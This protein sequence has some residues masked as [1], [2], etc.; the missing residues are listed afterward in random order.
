M[1]AIARWPTTP[2]KVGQTAEE[3]DGQWTETI[4]HIVLVS[5]GF[6][7]S[8]NFGGKVEWEEVEDRT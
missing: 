8:V 5:S 6:E 1:F 2:R 7:A 3:N 4:L